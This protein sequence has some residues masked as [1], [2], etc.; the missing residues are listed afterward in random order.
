MPPFT[1]PFHLTLSLL[2]LSPSLASRPAPRLRSRIFGGT[3][4]LQKLVRRESVGI[5][6]PHMGG[7]E[8]YVG[9][10]GED[11]G[12]LSNYEIERMQKKQ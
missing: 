1:S 5:K 9:V 4:G 11:T 6:P 10:R 8:R 7:G 3:R 2:L 12:H